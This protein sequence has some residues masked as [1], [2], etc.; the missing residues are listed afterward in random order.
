[1]CSQQR[2]GSFQSSTGRGR[3]F[4]RGTRGKE[5]QEWHLGPWVL[6]GYREAGWI[7]KGLRCKA[8]VH[9]QSLSP[10]P[11]SASAGFAETGRCGH[12]TICVVARPPP[13][14][15]PPP[16]STAST[17]YSPALGRPSKGWGGLGNEHLCLV[18]GRHS[19]KGGMEAHAPSHPHS[20]V[21][22]SNAS[23]TRV[24][25]RITQRIC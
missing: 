12:A 9:R 25:F 2:V 8:L 5:G 17:A 20:T 13:A 6:L 23:Q 18:G 16:P 7:G 10:D 3:D 19:K 21:S 4:S 1:M 11:L 15:P 24:S 14:G 22:N